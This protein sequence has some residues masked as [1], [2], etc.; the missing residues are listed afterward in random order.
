M[1]VKRNISISPHMQHI[2]STSPDLSKPI[3]KLI[4]RLFKLDIR[5]A[6][7]IFSLNECRSLVDG[8]KRGLSKVDILHQ[9]I[10]VMKT[11]RFVSYF[12]YCLLEKGKSATRQFVKKKSTM[13]I[14]KHT[15]SSTVTLNKL[16][17]HNKQS[18]R[19][20]QY[21]H[22]WWERVSDRTAQTNIERKRDA[23]FQEIESIKSTILNYI[24][25]GVNDDR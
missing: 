21:K 9:D 18:K 13:N 4:S 1:L 23:Y 19:I 7:S 15:P 10:S 14:V 2:I 16:L 3:S 5:Y 22:K 11:H 20:I 24:N 6:Q 8:I 17:K 25:Q 12:F